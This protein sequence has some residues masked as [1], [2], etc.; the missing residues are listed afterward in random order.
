M[1]DEATIQE[2]NDDGTKNPAYVVPKDESVID[3][4]KKEVKG[5]DGSE[6]KEGEDENSFNDE[7]DP[8]KPPEIPIRKNVISQHIIARKNEKI[9]KLESKLKEGDAGYVAPAATEDETE[10]D[11]E[12]SPAASKAIDAKLGKVI[13]PLLG[14]LASDA[15]EAEMKALIKSEPEAAKYVNH[16]KAY[17]S[18]E[19]WKNVPP[20]AIYH[21]LA[22]N[23]AQSLGAKKKLAADL[24]AKQNKGGGRTIVDKGVAGDLPS[25]QDIADMSDADFEKMENEARQGKFLK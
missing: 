23:A 11:S 18:H 22:W 8:N 7:I 20:T 19:A 4:T 3:D 13:A 15:D 2:Y 1:A 9:Q 5:E 6:K 16:I 10:D 25:A 14:K 12:L 21:H 17:M 24:E